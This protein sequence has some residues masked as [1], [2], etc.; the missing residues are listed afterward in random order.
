MQI[1]FEHNSRETMRAIKSLTAPLT[2]THC[3]PFVSSINSKVSAILASARARF[4]PGNFCARGVCTK[5]QAPASAVLSKLT[6]LFKPARERNF[7][8]GKFAGLKDHVLSVPAT[9]INSAKQRNI[10]SERVATAKGKGEEKKERER[11]V[12]KTREK[13][14]Q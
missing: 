10:R 4:S 6:W 8:S 1:F 14:P 12:R 7:A 11:R 5:K 3:L 2:H 9:R 13:E